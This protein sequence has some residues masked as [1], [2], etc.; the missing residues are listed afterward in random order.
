MAERNYVLVHGGFHGGWCYARVA[1]M[2]R[3]LGHNVYTPTLTGLGDRSHLAH[4]SVDCT[5]HILDVVNLITWERL[6]DVILVGH[7]YGGFIIGGV[8]EKIPAKIA[9]VVYLDAVIPVDGMAMMDV[10]DDA[11]VP[12]ILRAAG[13]N[14][15]AL[16][17][18][19]PA[20]AFG[21]NAKDAP[22]VDALV[23]PQ[24]LLTFTERL[25][26]TDAYMSIRKK[27]FIKA[28]HYDRS[29]RHYQ[30]VKNDPAWSCHVVDCGHDIMLDAPEELTRL[31]LAAA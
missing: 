27:V 3:G 10:V 30:S 17:P 26:L 6:E 28:K 18:S 19:F 16:I 24:P 12:G 20:S 4:R 21:V 31:L 13:Q 25:T 5:T 15:G 7:S 11:D 22:M 1:K 9:T 29:E 14:G 8:C 23:T 2:L